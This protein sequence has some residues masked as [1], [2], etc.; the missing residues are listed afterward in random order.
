MRQIEVPRRDSARDKDSHSPPKKHTGILAYFSPPPRVLFFFLVLLIQL[1]WFLLPFYL[2]LIF[3]AVGL[4]RALSAAGIILGI[5]LATNAWFIAIA[6]KLWLTSLLGPMTDN[7]FPLGSGII[8]LVTS[9][10]VNIQS[11]LIFTVME[12][13]VFVLA[14]IWY[15]FNCRRYPHTGPVLAMFPL[16][17]AWRSL[18]S[19]F[20]YIDIT[21]LAAVITDEYRELPA[22]SQLRPA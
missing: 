18:W 16:F 1:A 7:L 2:I 20:F 15:F 8:T 9:G 6:P 22:P 11:P 5:F 10:V 14:V 3:R 19:Y 17:F 21:V 13:I 12:G 4:K